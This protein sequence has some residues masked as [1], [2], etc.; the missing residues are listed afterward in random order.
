MT[1]IR[2]TCALALLAIAPLAASA[3][4]QSF[5][6]TQE[7]FDVLDVNKDGKVSADEYTTFMRESFDKLDGNSDAVLTTTEL[8][9]PLPAEQ[10]AT[11]DKN[12]TGNVSRDEF[13]EQVTAD[14]KRYDYNQD[15]HLQ[16]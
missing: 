8:S 6:L 13:M 16:P 7:H 1:I 5:I 11:L 4:P 15:G 10:I 3:Q 12:K 14:F 9:E 2:T